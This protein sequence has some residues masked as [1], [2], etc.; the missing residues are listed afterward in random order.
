[1][2]A[3]GWYV[4]PFGIHDGSVHSTRQLGFLLRR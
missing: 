3:E 4:D 2:S 1:M